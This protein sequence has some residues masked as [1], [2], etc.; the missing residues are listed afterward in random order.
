MGLGA[1]VGSVIG[2]GASIFGSKKAADAQADAASSAAAVEKEMFDQVYGDLAP[3]RATGTRALGALENMFLPQQEVNPEYTAAQEELAALKSA[4]PMVADQ[5]ARLPY[6][7]FG[8]DRMQE[9]YAAQQA[10]PRPAAPNPAIQQAEQKLANIP[11]YIDV[12]GGTGPDYSEFYK[13]P[14]YEFRLQEGVNALDR[15]A[16]ARGKLNSGQ[17]GKALMEYGQ[18]I[19][20]AEF[21]NYANRL[22]ALAGTGQ[23]A[24][25]QGGQF[26]MASAANQGNAMMNA[27]AARASGYAGMANAVNRGVENVMGLYGMGA[28]G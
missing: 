8:S 3:Y 28:F 20:S 25:A 22:A 17:Q 7:R 5:P 27:G 4:P 10:Q 14:G 11:Q 23:T 26:G 1:V 9:R 2:V 15:S 24:V 16:A 21:G 12:S 13:S 19:A 6:M 18:G